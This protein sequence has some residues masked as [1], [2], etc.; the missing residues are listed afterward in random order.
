MFNKYSSIDIH[1]L[2]HDHSLYQRPQSK[3]NEEARKNNTN[4]T[5]KKQNS[6]RHVASPRAKKKDQKG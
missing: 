1:H 5:Q 2:Y 6:E 3:R 4:T